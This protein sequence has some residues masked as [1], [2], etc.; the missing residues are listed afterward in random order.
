MIFHIRKGGMKRYGDL[1]TFCIRNSTNF[2]FESTKKM[3]LQQKLVSEN[4]EFKTVECQNQFQNV[5]LAFKIINR[6]YL[7]L[8]NQLKQPSVFG[9]RFSHPIN[10]SCVL[11]SPI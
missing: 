8:L 10:V 4:S 5:T 6:L 11:I 7:K 3:I 1:R 9:K 2:A